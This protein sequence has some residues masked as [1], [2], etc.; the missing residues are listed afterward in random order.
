MILNIEDDSKDKWSA[1]KDYSL[2]TIINA[3]DN[4]PYWCIINEIKKQLQKVSKY[5]VSVEKVELSS[6]MYK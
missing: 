4:C 3:Y 2:F 6:K 1:C 5:F